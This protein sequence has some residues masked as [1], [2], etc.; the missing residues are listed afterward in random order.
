MRL[1]QHGSDW[2]VLEARMAEMRDGDVDWRN[3]RSALHIYD[4]DDQSLA[5]A[6]AAYT[7]FMSENALAPTAFPS[8]RR[9]ETD[10]VDISL[11]LMN[12]P[13]DA[14][15]NVTTGGTESII[16]VLKAARDRDRGRTRRGYEHPEVLLPETAHPAYDKAAHLL[17]MRVRRVPV[18]SDWSADPEVMRNAVTDRTVLM[19]ASAPCLPFGTIDPIEEIAEIA[20][21]QEVWLHV[22]ACIGGFLAPFVRALGYPVSTFD[23]SI[24]GV[25]SISADLHK[26]GYAPKGASVILYASKSDQ[27][28]QAYDFSGWPKG[29]YFTPTVVGTRSGGAIASAWAVLH[30]LGHDGYLARAR[31]VMKVRDRYLEGIHY[32]Q[33]LIPIGKPQLSVIAFGSETFDIFAVANELCKDGWYVSRLA[34]PRALHQTVTLAHTR[35]VEPYLECLESAVRRVKDGCLVANGHSVVTY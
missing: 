11:D 3:G 34:H 20:R 23:F 5:I 10:I 32:I 33:G 7:M 13:P 21:R 27:Q 12:A 26:F 19:V 24:P 1:P 8:I 17:D 6:R 2:N 4:V 35:A 18:R 9:M 31:T 30:H 16:L 22:D 14:C 15:G 28:F 25:R 29:R